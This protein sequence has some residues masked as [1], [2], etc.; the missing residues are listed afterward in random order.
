MDPQPDSVGEITLTKT[1]ASGTSSDGESDVFQAS[2]PFSP[3]Q[4]APVLPQNDQRSI[5][6]VSTA[7]AP[8]CPIPGYGSESAGSLRLDGPGGSFLI[9]PMSDGDKVSYQRTL[10]IGTLQPGAYTVSSA[11]SSGVRPFESVIQLGSDIQISGSYPPGTSISDHGSFQVSW[12][13]GDDDEIVKV[14]LISHLFQFDTIHSQMVPATA[15]SIALQGPNG[16]L[17]LQASNNAELVFEVLP[18][19]AATFSASG[20]ALGGYLNW[21]YKHRFAGLAIQ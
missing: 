12:A 17:G 21:E 3:G 16:F 1:F 10:P 4:P 13:G 6:G 9:A 19:Q 20:L 8:A 5:Y 2:F 18:K 11:G 7:S 14:T 15:H